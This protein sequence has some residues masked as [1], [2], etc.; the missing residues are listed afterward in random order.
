MMERMMIHS[1]KMT[2][3][4]QFL[5]G[6]ETIAGHYY[7]DG[8]GTAVEQA[9]GRGAFVQIKNVAAPSSGFGFVTTEGFGR[10]GVVDLATV[11]RRRALDLAMQGV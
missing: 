7:P 1:R 4:E 6:I 11:R 8:L 5:D 3:R 9:I 10:G 2:K